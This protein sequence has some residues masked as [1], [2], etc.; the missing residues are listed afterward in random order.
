MSLHNCYSIENINSEYQ[1][2]Q[3]NK[4][5]VY[6]VFDDIIQKVVC[7]CCV[8]D[9][10]KTSPA[11]IDIKLIQE[12]SAKLLV[13]C[14]ICKI[15]VRFG[16]FIDH[17]RDNHN[18]I[19]VKIPEPITHAKSIGTVVISA[20]NDEYDD[21]DFFNQPDVLS[22]IEDSYL[23]LSSHQEAVVNHDKPWFGH[24]LYVNSKLELN[25]MANVEFNEDNIPIIAKEK[26]DQRDKWK[27][28]T[29]SESAS[30][31]SSTV[32][33]Q[34]LNRQ[35]FFGALKE[36][37][38]QNVDGSYGSGYTMDMHPGYIFI[39]PTTFMMKNQFLYSFYADEMNR[40]I[41]DKEVWRMMYNKNHP[42]KSQPKE[43][44]RDAWE[45]ICIDLFKI[46]PLSHLKQHFDTYTVISD[47]A[48]PIFT[49]RSTSHSMSL[50]YMSHIRKYIHPGI[51]TIMEEMKDFKLFFFGNEIEELYTTWVPAKESLLAL[52]ID[53]LF[54]LYNIFSKTGMPNIKYYYFKYLFF[55]P[56]IDVKFMDG[57][58]HPI[59]NH[60]NDII[61][62]GNDINLIDLFS[63]FTNTCSWPLPRFPIRFKEQI[64]SYVF[65]NFPGKM[66]P[67]TGI[68]VK[69]GVLLTIEKK[70]GD[71]DTCAYKSDLTTI[72]HDWKK[73]T[74]GFNEKQVF[75]ELKKDRVI[76]YFDISDGDKCI[77]SRENYFR[78]QML[79][80]A[81][82]TFFNNFIQYRSDPSYMPKET[83][84]IHPFADMKYI[85]DN[86]MQWS[87]EQEL[88]MHIFRT[89]PIVFIGGE[90]G[91]GKT[92]TMKRI[93]NSY[94][95]HEVLYTSAVATTVVD[96]GFKKICRR[97]LTMH[98]CMII[99][100]MFC[101][102]N[103]DPD[104]RKHVLFQ[105]RMYCTR[106]L[107]YENG[108]LTPD[109]EM[110]KGC[111]YKCKP[112][113]NCYDK[114]PFERIRL[115]IIDEVGIT[116]ITNIC[117]MLY[118]LCK[119]AAEDV[120]VVIGGDGGQLL[121]IAPGDSYRDLYQILK[122]LSVVYRID[123]RIVGAKS[124][125]RMSSNRAV[126]ECDP[127]NVHYG[128]KTTFVDRQMGR[129]SKDTM[130]ISQI[131]GFHFIE[132]NK[133]VSKET[134]QDM[135]EKALEPTLKYLK[136]KPE[137]LGHI[138]KYGVS[139]YLRI[140]CPTHLHKNA[141]SNWIKK[142]IFIPRA[143]RTGRIFKENIFSSYVDREEVFKGMKVI[144]TMNRYKHGLHNNLPYIVYRIQDV[145]FKTRGNK[146]MDD[147]EED[148]TK[149]STSSSDFDMPDI[150]DDIISE[151]GNE[152]LPAGGGPLSKKKINEDIENEFSKYGFDDSTIIFGHEDLPS[153]NVKEPFGMPQGSHGRRLIVVPISDVDD[154]G[155]VKTTKNQKIIP[156]TH[157]HWFLVKSASASTIFSSQGGQCKVVI[158]FIPTFFKDRDTSNLLYVAV[159]RATHM[160]VIVS[161]EEILEQMIKNK[162]KERKTHYYDYIG[163]KIQDCYDHDALKVNDIPEELQQKMNADQAVLD[164]L[165]KKI[166]EFRKKSRK[167]DKKRRKIVPVAEPDVSLEDATKDLGDDASA[168]LVGFGK[169]FFSNN[170]NKLRAAKRA[171]RNEEDMDMA[172]KD[173][174][175]EPLKK[176]Q[177][178]V[179]QEPPKPAS[180]PP[181][182]KKELF[183]HEQKKKKKANKK[184]NR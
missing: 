55:R 124:L 54:V 80:I 9:I 68:I 27:K 176:K 46:Y 99:H 155:T 71:S 137:Y 94:H 170:M 93:C 168:F 133:T 21:G 52:N 14:S 13:N 81:L 164:D 58:N 136:S 19:N 85:S 8:I 6:P 57:L 139:D 160:V 24:D 125:A 122:P 171:T 181:P 63:C 102:N 148:E 162:A 76:K 151:E 108:K 129:Y 59:G 74:V 28:T 178:L 109:R 179:P 95:K 30:S 82:R 119:C 169:S 120:K 105:C 134:N 7:S 70:I 146:K 161:T 177:S 123:H 165:D 111:K 12:E 158:I 144:Y 107:P 77:M 152:A 18:D 60:L 96:V 49:N 83:L 175:F 65:I 117:R 149:T 87:G 20:T 147:I 110:F 2:Q 118:L 73:R 10:N 15:K 75:E 142:N 5:L 126:R 159:T 3:C 140:I 62:R 131:E 86:Q 128:M 127:I 67:D 41:N 150:A 184:I 32:Q 45:S 64:A 103:A 154:D 66:V 101:L 61:I 166:E 42:F 163:P 72:L 180:L 145:A 100:N 98:R 138:E 116:D 37:V 26:K 48:F 51:R 121:S 36:E 97:S 132:I 90:A 50:L 143:E 47:E 44:S 69:S 4:L 40:E 53:G 25:S 115:V 92:E 174:K 167:N 106:E 88:A 34:Y 16:S 141:I 156:W 135:I 35:H 182:S 22:A 11:Q 1:C 78:A 31:S 89:K 183:L 43:W 112:M 173:V 104:Q 38:V 91:T 17:V 153:T 113:Y 23:I 79:L 33:R 130:P 172:S 84:E 39:F 56:N 29:Q 114:C 157:N